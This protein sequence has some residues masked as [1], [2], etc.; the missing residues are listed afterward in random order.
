MPLRGPLGP[1]WGR[2]SDVDTA[3]EE[4]DVADAQPERLALS[5]PASG[6][7]DSD[8]AV[9]ARQ[10]VDDGPHLSACPWLDFSVSRFG[11]RTDLAWQGLVAIRPSSKAALNTAETLVKIVRT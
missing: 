4:V 3:A 1:S 7:D 5:K 2:E 10:G 11:S 9:A 6:G 8:G